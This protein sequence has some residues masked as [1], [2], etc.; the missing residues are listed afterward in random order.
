MHLTPQDAEHRLGF[1]RI[2]ERLHSHVRTP[3][4]QE[5][6]GALRP[7]AD[8]AEVARRLEKAGEMQA[9]LGFDDPL[10][11]SGSVDIRP[12]LEHIAPEGSTASGEELADAGRV[13]TS[14]RL[15]H[16]YLK[17]RKVKYSGLWSVAEAIVP[18]QSVETTISSA[19][20]DQGRVKDDA[21]PVLQRITRTLAD[22][23]GKLRETLMQALRK[24]VSE[25]WATEEQPTIRG[26]RAVIPVRAEAKR[27][28]QGFVH[29]VSATGQ[30]VY[31]EPTSVLDLNNE[32]RELESERSREIARILA[33]V[34]A[35]LRTHRK[36]IA[37]GLDALGRLDALAAIGRLANELG[38][39][40]PALNEDRVIRL[41]RARNPVLL[42]HFRKSGPEG[43]RRE[44]VPLDLEL[45]KDANTLVITGPNAGGKSVAMKSIGL[46]CL[47]AQIGIPVPADPG[48]SLPV[49]SAIFVDL[50]DRQSIQEDLSTFTSHLAAIRNMIEVA[51]EGSL[52]LIDEAGPGTDPAE[53]S[54]LAQAVLEKLTKQGALTVATTHH[55]GLK[56][57][58]H[59][60]DGVVN[61][62]MQFDRESLSPTYHFQ[63]ETP[64]SSY[65]FEIAARVGLDPVVVS[66][67]RELVGEDKVA[68]EELID[69]LERTTREASEAR[70]VIEEELAE[71]RKAHAKYESQAETL[72]TE[73]DTLRARALEEAADI[74]ERANAL[75]ENT[76]REIK[77]AE[78]EREATREA[79]K[80]LDEGRIRIEREVAEARQKRKDREEGKPVSMAIEVG[81]RVRLDQGTTTGEVVEIDGKEAVVAFGSMTT[82]TALNRLQKVADR[83]EQKVEIKAYPASPD[84]GAMSAV[85]TR[86]DLRGYRVDEAVG[87]LAKFVD[88]AMV[89]GLSSVEVLHGKGTGALRNAVRDVLES[90]PEVTSFDSAPWNEGGDGV[91]IVRLS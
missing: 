73:R 78:A 25:G 67:A 68:L 43:E 57:F 55:G 41:V 16:D 66:R 1:D 4:G 71:A 86:L 72:R 74:V 6:L 52:V 37:V 54:A 23:Q 5:K 40:V 81:D 7:S 62:S 34:T 70:A 76:V 29:D 75:V 30:T 51:D 65:A 63:P 61:G 21:S 8:A 33:A 77:E 82:R 35:E 56:V 50:G 22:R 15:L 36:E 14:L 18:V 69:A 20:D 39:L 59:N 17:S 48:T 19:I 26:G 11:L 12:L 58:A 87:A 49:L 79:R 84:V 83:A 80:K 46:M 10:P 42:L 90:R 2:R 27:K 45:G 47:M 60:T 85:H 9:V 64:G 91:T 32:I 44:V 3:Y 88:Q 53:G 24:A 13:L 31:I 38:A 28:V 89:S